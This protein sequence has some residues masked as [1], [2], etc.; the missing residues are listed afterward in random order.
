MKAA[1]LT[2]V[3][4]FEIRD[5][6]LPDCPEDGI[7]LKVKACGVCGSD[8]RRWREGPML[9]S[10]PPIPGHEIA[11]EVIA[12]GKNITD[13]TIGERLAVA[14]DIHCGNC[15][16]CEQGLYNLCDNLRLIG[17]TP[18]YDGGFTEYMVLTGEILRNGIVHRVPPGLSDLQAALAEPAS[19][20]LA[21]HER[22]GT[23]LGDT[24][25]VMGAGPIGCL[26]VI[27]A[28]ARGARVLLSEPHAGR[29]QRGE[30]FGPDGIIDPSQQDVVAQVREM[31]DGRGVDIVI[32]ANPIAETQT[33]AVEVV[34]KRGRV[35]LFGGLPKDHPM[36]VLNANLIHYGEIQVVGSFSY[37][38]IF[39]QRALD[40]IKQG[41][42]P[43][44]KLITHT[45]SLDQIN[46]AFQTAAGGDALKVIITFETGAAS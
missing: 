25:L 33:Q 46:E 19:S 24:V 37:H 29:R 32:C 43:S 39:H 10:I 8:L 41:V 45:F 27:V 13:Y 16:Y 4:R 35:V 20:V 17:I 15:Y 6:P 30:V 26:H 12:I 18:G 22:V 40:L 21:A 28:K 3:M 36:T 34:R 23:S 5:I 42:I 7:I 14:P 31:T 2:S 9:S 38:P 1:F 44:D 11:G